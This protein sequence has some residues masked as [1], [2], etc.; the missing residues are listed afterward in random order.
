MCR[1]NQ[2]L[3]LVPSL[4]DLMQVTPNSRAL[5]T[6]QRPCTDTLETAKGLE[7]PGSE[8]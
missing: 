4:A 6:L 1:Q 5:T 2:S 8:E 3:I 7:K